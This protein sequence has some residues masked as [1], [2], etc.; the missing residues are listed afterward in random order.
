MHEA[1]IQ[2]GDRSGF[3]RLLFNVQQRTL[4]HTIVDAETL[5]KNVREG[6]AGYRTALAGA[7]DFARQRGAAFV[8]FVQPHIFTLPKHSSHERWLI[9]NELKNLPGLDRA[10]QIAYPRLKRAAAQGCGSSNVDLA[11]ALDGHDAETELYF[12]FCHVNHMANRTIARR[13]F[14]SAFPS[15]SRAQPAARVVSTYEKNER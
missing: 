15:R 10:F 5:E 3:V 14:E 12:D 13:I 6:E 1:F 2:H 11:D 8:H 7:R 9:E 4:P